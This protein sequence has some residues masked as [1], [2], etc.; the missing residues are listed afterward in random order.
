[1]KLDFAF[2]QYQ[3]NHI[4][5]NEMGEHVAGIKQDRYLYKISLKKEVL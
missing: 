3:S 4:E 5:V 1:M 2:H